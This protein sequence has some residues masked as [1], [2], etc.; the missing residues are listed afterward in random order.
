MQI[1]L[2]VLYLSTVW[3]KLQGDTWLDGSAV[4]YVLRQDDLLR[5]ELPTAFTGSPVVSAVLTY[6]TLGVELAVGVLIWSRRAR[7]FVVVPA[8]L[9]HVLVDAILAAALISAAMLTAFVSFV[10]PETASRL[11]AK[12]RNRGFRLLPERRRSP[13][14]EPASD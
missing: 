1:Q 13:R 14:V 6:G 3:Q 2:S 7:P 4:S 11:I 10:P 9:L 5:V 8:I 12:V